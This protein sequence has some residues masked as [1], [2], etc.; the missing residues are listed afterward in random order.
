LVLLSITLNKLGKR[1]ITVNAVAPGFIE[2]KMTAVLPLFVKEVGRR[3]SN[4]S[5]GG[6]LEDVGQLITFLISPGSYGITGQV[7][8]VCGGALLGA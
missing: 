3:L 6:L 4:L 2:T 7:I 8:R 5:Q 1:G